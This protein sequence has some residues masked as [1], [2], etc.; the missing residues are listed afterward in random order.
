M[1]HIHCEA[2]HCDPDLAL[3]NQC[4]ASHSVF[5]SV[6]FSHPLPLPS[7]IPLAQNFTPSYR[8][9]MY[10]QSSIALHTFKRSPRLVPF[11]HPP[12]A[13]TLYLKFFKHCTPSYGSPFSLTS[14]RSAF[15]SIEH[16]I[17]SFLPKFILKFLLSHTLPNSLTSVDNFSSESATTAVS[18]ANNSWFKSATIRVQQF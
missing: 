14:V 5:A 15:M 17:T 11:S 16:F 9:F 1:P 18:S 10:S 6:H 13:V 4:N 2:L 12:S 7:A 3:H 8:H